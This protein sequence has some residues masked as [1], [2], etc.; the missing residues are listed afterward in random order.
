MS[1]L[2][3]VK[4]KIGKRTYTTKVYASNHDDIITFVNNNLKSKVVSIHEIVYEAPKTQKYEVDDPSTYKGTMYFMVANNEA[5]KSNQ[6]IFQTVKTTRN[7]NEVF[8]DM[9]QLLHLD[10][11]TSIKSLVTASISDK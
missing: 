5:N 7:V 6:M 2:Y 8:Q 4:L 11:T 9:K 3:N 1:H 10:K